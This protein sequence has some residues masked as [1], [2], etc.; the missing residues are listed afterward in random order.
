MQEKEHNEII[1][2]FW[3]EMLLVGFSLFLE[4]GIWGV[5]FYN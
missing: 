3:G 5:E 2:T 1:H 4:K